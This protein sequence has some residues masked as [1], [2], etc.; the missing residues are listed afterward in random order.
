VS[1]YSAASKVDDIRGVYPPQDVGSSG[2]AVMKVCK[3]RRYIKEYRH[4]F[5]FEETLR[6]LVLAPV[7]AGINW[8]EGFD[9]PSRSGECKMRGNVR[10]GHEIVVD[11]ID[12]ERKRVWASQS[13]GPEWGIDG[14]FYFSFATFEALLHEDGD[15]TTAVPTARRGPS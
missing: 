6:A 7:I 11:A 8:Y 9:T 13:W 10:G 2:L 15:V 12:V 14:R 3:K 5:G 4:A 1:I